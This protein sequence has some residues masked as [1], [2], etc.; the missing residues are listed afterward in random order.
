L[1]AD[2]RVAIALALAPLLGGCPPQCDHTCRKLLDCGEEV[3]AQRVAQ[4]L[5]E[6]ECKR[7][8]ALYE[9]WE[10]DEKQA[11]FDD[12]KR[13]IVH[14]SCDELASGAC[15]DPGLFPFGQY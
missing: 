14:S 1:R 10:D 3:D 2:L 9:S 5:C 13:C 4:A 12:E 7:E 15:Y 8:D 11:A 6:D